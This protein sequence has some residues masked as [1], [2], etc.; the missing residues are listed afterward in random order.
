[1]G[2]L[3]DSTNVI[4][5]VVS[6]ITNVA[7]DHTDRCGKTLER[8]AMQKA[9]IIKEKVPLVTAA[10]G[11]EAL[12]PIVSLAMFKEAPVY[13]YGKAFHGTEVKSSMEGQAFT[14]HAGDFYH[15][16]YEI[17]LPGEHQIKNTSVAIVAAKLVSKQDDRINELALHVGVANTV[18]PGR[19]ER[20][21]K[22]PDIILDGAHNHDGAKALRNALDKYYPG[23]QVQFV[24]GMMGDKDMSGVIK[25]LINQDDVVYTVRA[26]E[27]ARAAEAADLAKLVGSNAVAE[28]NLATA[29]DAAI[30][31]A[32]TDGVVCVCGSLYLVGEFKKMLLA[33][34][35]RMN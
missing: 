35:C 6:V 13:L 34:K 30:R 25:T 7:L 9:G 21:H 4:T 14:L 24:F 22:N 28:A 31:G 5:P 17:K 33:D 11:N 12:G 16:D 26:D 18:W 19:L 29:Y 20:I 10:E 32:G 8:I 1:M 2:G 15:S 23:K 27:G 3:W